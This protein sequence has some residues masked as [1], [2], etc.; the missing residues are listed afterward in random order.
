[1]SLTFLQKRSLTP[2]HFLLSRRLTTGYLQGYNLAES[3]QTTQREAKEWFSGVRSYLRFLNNRRLDTRFSVFPG[4]REVLMISTLVILISVASAVFL[5]PLYLSWY[6]YEIALRLSIFGPITTLGNS[7]WTL[8]LCGTGLL[9]LSF[10]RSDRFKGAKY[11]SWH[12]ALLTFYF[13]FTNVALSG[14]TAVFLKNLIGK[15]RPQYAL[16]TENIHLWTF[17][18]FEDKYAFAAFPSGHATTAGAMIAAC[19]ILFPRWGWLMIPV[20]LW[21]AVSRAAIGVHYPSD[22]I[23]GVLFGFVFTWFYARAFARKR[24]IFMFDDKGKL[25]IRGN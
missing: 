4:W 11:V 12:R 15:A 20:G 16:Y 25:C 14:L 2:E 13:I 23:A 24:L 5:D 9:V 8:L 18:P 21:V 7:I 22:V 1:M 19:W 6:E 10:F 3:V 17:M